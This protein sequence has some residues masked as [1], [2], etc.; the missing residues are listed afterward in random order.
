MA[1]RTTK[2]KVKPAQQ[3]YPTQRDLIVLRKLDIRFPGSSPNERANIIEMLST[4]QLEPG[5]PEGEMPWFRDGYVTND[6]PRDFILTDKLMKV[7]TGFAI[8]RTDTGEIL[9][10]FGPENLAAADA[11]IAKAKVQ[12]PS[13]EFELDSEDEADPEPEADAA[14]VSFDDLTEDE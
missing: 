4:A 7:T 2:N 3:V 13:I 6:H 1:V 11:A 10:E 8:A 9:R 5:V 14:P 12:I